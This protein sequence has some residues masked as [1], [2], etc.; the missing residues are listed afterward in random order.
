MKKTVAFLLGA[1]TVAAGHAQLP[2]WVIDPAND[3]L[4][5]KIDNSLIQGQ[6]NGESSLWTM[7][8][9]PVYKTSDE[10]MP[11]KDDVAAILMK[12]KP[13]I[14]GFIDS[15][16][17]FTALP[18]VTVA[19]DNPYFE[20][21]FILCNEK[22]SLVFFNKDGA[23]AGFPR[24][25]KAYPFHAGYAPFLTYGQW[26][27]KKDPHYGYF[28]ADGQPMKYR[29]VENGN[30]KEIEPKDVDF[31]SG[32]GTNGKGVGV[33]RKKLYW[34]DAASAT[35]EPL[36]WGEEESVKKRHLAT[37][38]NYE[39]YFLDLPADTVVIKARYGK[40][41]S[42]ELRFDR[43]LR[44]DA[45]VFEDYVMTFAEKP[46][47]RFEYKSALSEYGQDGG[48]GLDFNSRHVL[49]QQFD[50]V[51]VK[52][53]NRAFVRLNGK[54]GVIGIVPGLE[55]TL[56]INK[57]E[58]IAFRHQKFETQ[59]RLDLPAQISARDAR[60]DIPEATGCLIDKT[61]R[62]SKD[63]ESGN[64]VTYTCD[65]N[66]PASLPDT[67]TPITYSPVTVSYDGVSLFPEQITVR[68]W[69]LKYYNV[70]PIDSETSISNGVASFT[71]NINAQRN[72]GEG[73][74]P[75]DV[76]IEADSIAVQYEK[77][78]ET[79]YK[80]LVSNLQEGD[81]SLNIYVTEK[82]C[83]SSVFPFEIHYT[84]PVPRKKKKEE[85]VIRKKDSHRLAL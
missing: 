28:R 50:K 55:Y 60:I 1:L 58:D 11:F 3:T 73:D 36:L 5:I 33:I 49:P 37:D 47:A 16:G 15:R 38:G 26:D 22:D 29:I 53:G 34:F 56:R 23:R 80:C 17:K 19:Y 12:D 62:E 51:S 79:R 4:F 64:Y 14:T 78:S 30:M 75:F 71:L 83:P 67:I 68:A 63:T 46:A 48:Y 57:G 84:K 39:Q 72:V 74:Y 76:R 54:W 32:I 18:A 69:H 24:V 70:D 43:E 40:G 7:D 42:A 77:L 59:I 82:G 2:K 41:Q 9:N 61:S 81:N 21:G 27:K 20:N 8:G 13:V 44:P 65:L 6:A 35:F 85:V 52:Y 10:I 45:F 25:L 66:I 31:L